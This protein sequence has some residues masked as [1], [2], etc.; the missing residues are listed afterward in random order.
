MMSR[1]VHRAGITAGSRM[2][3][4]W[5]TA[6]VVIGILAVAICI[7]PAQAQQGGDTPIARLERARAAQPTSANI[8]RAL[9]IAY[10]RAGRHGEAMP[11][12]L[13]ARRLAPRDGTS[14]LYAG[15]TAEALGDIAAAREAYASYLTHGR[16]RRVRHQ[17]ASRLATLNRQELAL[18]ARQSIAQEQA[19]GSLPGSPHTIAVPALGFSGSDSTLRPL[20]RGLADLMITDLG[21]SQ[22]LTLVERDRM[23]ALLDEIERS[24]PGRGDA[25]TAVRAGRMVRAGRVVQ[26]AITQLPNDALRVDATIVDVPTT[27]SVD[28]VSADDRLEQLFALEKRIVFALFEAL[29]VT[30]TPA[31]RALV[32]QRPTRS[33]AA[34][35][36]YSAG[37]MAAD[38]G[39][40]ATAAAHFAEAVRLD[41][42]FAA[43]RSRGEEARAAESGGRLTTAAIE[44]ALG[45][46]PEGAV[47]RAADRGIATAEGAVGGTL[48]GTLAMTAQSINPS[49]LLDAAGGSTLRQ[50]LPVRDPASAVTNT[51]NPI[52][53]LGTLIIIIRQPAP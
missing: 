10:Y 15:L 41:P 37:L 14:A 30:L 25:T 11:V 45:G 19:V 2:L 18:A 31:E 13:E 17:L 5:T 47:V 8:L 29:G 51:D 38:S 28:A 44:A 6:R 3:R 23:Q 22:A 53:G 49:P 36:S 52:S 1:G 42:G 9:G 24:G 40:L 12:L 46:T 21:R 32:D 33:M 4:A 20:G 43:A 39:N 7:A 27:A 34:F 26:G 48:A 50:V 16:T 35:V